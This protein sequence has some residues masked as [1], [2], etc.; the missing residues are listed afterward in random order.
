MSNNGT[1]QV[2][3][4]CPQCK[5]PFRVNLP[6]IGTVNSPTFS[7]A[8]GTHEKPIRCPKCGSHYILAAQFVADW[9]MMPISDEDAAKLQGSS[10]IVPIP[11]LLH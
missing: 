7:M 9:A 11:S 6:K 2:A 1:N 8:I 3:V 5:L 10:I 4:D